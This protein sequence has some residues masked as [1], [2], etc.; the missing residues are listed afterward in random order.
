[1]P[2]IIGD[3]LADHRAMTRH[4]L[5]DSLG[6]LLAEQSF[7]SIT[8]SQIAARAGVGR[9]AV[10]NHFEDKE[11]LL[12]SYMEEATREFAALVQ[13]ALETEPDTVE[14]FRIYIRAHLEMTNRYHLASRIHLREQVSPMNSAH[15]REHAG[16]IGEVLL[17]I[18]TDLMSD[19]AIPVQDPRALIPLIHACLASQELPPDPAQRRTAIATIEAFVLRAVGVAPDFIHPIPRAPRS[20][21]SLEDGA[22]ERAQAA[23]ARCPAVH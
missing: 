2:K 14:R 6:Q 16:I 23:F 3:S 7:D 9:T 18:L 20:P 5:F 1:M 11:V 21:G 12:L 22:P 10:Y 15:L 13:T 19:H 17:T 4:K 8:M